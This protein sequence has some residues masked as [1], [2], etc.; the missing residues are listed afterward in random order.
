MLDSHDNKAT[1]LK[2]KKE[3]KTITCTFS[4]VSANCVVDSIV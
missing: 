4:V 1:G 3:E 2:N